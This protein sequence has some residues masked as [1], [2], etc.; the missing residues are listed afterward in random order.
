MARPKP[1]VL[2]LYILVLVAAMLLLLFFDTIC[3]HEGHFKVLLQSVV[4]QIPESTS[5]LFLP[6]PPA[7][8]C[9]RLL[10]CW[11]CSKVVVCSAAFT[12]SGSFSRYFVRQSWSSTGGPLCQRLRSATPASGLLL[13]AWYPILGFVRVIG[14]FGHSLVVPS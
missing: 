12:P 6:F 7:V 8:L 3:P 11:L 10:V 14:S 4:V 2:C 5:H 13:G 1:I 9:I